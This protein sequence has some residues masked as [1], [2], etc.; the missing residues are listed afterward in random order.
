LERGSPRALGGRPSGSRL[1]WSTWALTMLLFGAT[2]VLVSLRSPETTSEVETGWASVVPV[3][4]FVVSY[5]TVG[6]LVIARHRSNKLGWSAAACGLMF[7]LASFGLV[8]GDE[9]AVVDVRPGGELL[10]TL[11]QWQWLAGIV[12]G[13]PF[14]ILFFP[15]G[16]LPSQRWRPV[17]AALIVGLAA[18]VVSTTFYPGR[19]PDTS[20]ENPLG[21]EAVGGILK[22]LGV[23]GGILVALASIGSVV[24]VIVR[25]RRAHETE[26][27]Q[28][29]WFVFAI[30]TA[31]V[32]VLGIGFPIEAL[33]YYEASNMIVTGA[34]SIIPISIGIAVLTRRF[35]DIDIV[36][37]KTLVYAI[38]SAVLAASYLALIF[39]LQE[40]TNVFGSDSDL[41]IA[42]STLAVAA[43]F[44][45]VRARVQRLI[46]RRF[47]R[48]RYDASHALRAFAVRLRDQVDLDAVNHEILAVVDNT[49]GPRH[50]GIWLAPRDG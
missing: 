25:F 50:A 49:V 33:G 48:R 5:A 47:Y 29:K 24:S 11:S 16:T 41:S 27:Q 15:R 19:V 9:G 1:A 35:Y 7:A 45:P 10:L 28:M 34:L 46:D 17:A 12:F 22:V 42:A 21:I 8:Y 3:A 2:F 39:I 26:R 32:I 4:V 36:I 6:A 18:V 14:L 38:L 31:V 20:L 13:G 44:G 23:L 40:V 30:V 43:L 37:N